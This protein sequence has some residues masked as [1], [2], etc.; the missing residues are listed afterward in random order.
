VKKGVAVAIC[1]LALLV[2]VFYT[3]PKIPPGVDL[4][5]KIKVLAG[6]DSK[7]DI[8]ASPV[9]IASMQNMLRQPLTY[10]AQ[11]KQ[12]HAYIS[13]DG[14][15]V[16]KLLL[17]RPLRIDSWV[18]NL[19]NVYPISLYRNYKIG[20]RF[21][22]KDAL[23]SSFLLAYQ[24]LPEETGT[25]F[26]HLNPTDEL[27]G[28]T[29]FIDR[30]GAPCIID[31]DSTHFVVQKKA[32]LLKPVIATLMWEGNIDEAKKKIDQV[33]M[34][35][36]SSAKKG[37]LDID[38]SL[39]RNNNIG[40]LE[41]QAIYID[42]GKLRLR[43]EMKEKKNFVQDLRRLKPLYKWLKLYYPELADYFVQKQ[44][45]VLHDF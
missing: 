10:L 31:L 29:L 43:P 27:F 41:N 18:R 12:S 5:N 40:L 45:Q 24:Q 13:R 9:L 16:V 38:K 4:S 8:D 19:P 22:R 2:W 39:I 36:A 20:K 34:L 30:T 11:G 14:Q 15:Y 26:V 6:S 17:Q 32:K 3:P 33:F 7:W 1:L 35:L 25:V 21:E 28:K 44:T 23:F 37:V 42:I